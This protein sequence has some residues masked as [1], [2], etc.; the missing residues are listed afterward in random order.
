MSTTRQTTR[1][2]APPLQV[3]RVLLDPLLIPRWRVPTDMRCEVHAFEP[4]EG[5]TFPVSTDPGSRRF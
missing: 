3:Y 1:I 4:R 5:G 2:D